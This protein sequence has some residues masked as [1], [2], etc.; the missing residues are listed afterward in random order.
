MCLLRTM[1]ERHL[2]LLVVLGLRRRVTE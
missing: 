2:R 1:R